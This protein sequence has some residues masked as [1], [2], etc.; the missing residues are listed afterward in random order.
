MAARQSLPRA[1]HAAAGIGSKLY[2]W[3]GYSGPSEIKSTAVLEIFDLTSASWEQPQLLGG[4][5]MPDGLQGMAVTSEGE[6]VHCC[7]GRTGHYPYTSYR[8]VFEI[9]PS[10]HLCRELQ[11]ASLSHT[12]PVERTLGCVVRFQDT[13]ILYGGYTGQEQTNELHV[14]DLKKS[15]SE[16]WYYMHDAC[17]I[18]LVRPLLVGLQVA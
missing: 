1:Y 6:T 17:S 18:A 14:F 16:L 12:P 13:L 5:D 7:C 11:P 15:E 9:T 4:S 10:Q 2:V 3:G 8:T